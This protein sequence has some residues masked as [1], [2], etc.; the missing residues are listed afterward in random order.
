MARIA[1]INLPKEKRIVRALT[2]IYGIGHTYASQILQATNTD[3][4]IRAKDLTS[5]DED[6]I[7]EL[8]EKKYK[9]EGNLRREVLGNIKRLKEIKSYRGSRHEKKLPVR[10]QRSKTNARTKRGRKQTAGSGRKK[11]AAKT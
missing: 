2:Y 9:V 3:P 10:G 8:I 6:K 7:R 4:D 5:A 11:S 1:G